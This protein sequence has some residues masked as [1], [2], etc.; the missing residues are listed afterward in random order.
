MSQKINKVRN[1][2]LQGR[3][4]IPRGWTWKGTRGTSWEHAGDGDHEAIQISSRTQKG[5]ATWSQV[6]SCKSETNY[7][8]EATISCGLRSDKD[9]GSAGLVLSVHPVHEDSEQ[10]RSR[11]TPGILRSSSPVAIRTIFLAG[12]GVRRLRISVGISHASGDAH[13]HEVRVIEMIDPD[14][15]SHPLAIPPPAHALPAPYKVRS[16][17][18]CSQTA[19]DRP[20][21]DLLARYFGRKK[22]ACLSPAD[23]RIGSSTADAI[24]FPDAAPPSGLRS[25]R[26]LFKLAGD[27]LVVIS[28]PAFAK[29]SNDA[30]RLR[31]ITQT[32]DPICAKVVWANHATRGFALNDMFPFAW[33]GKNPDSF[34][35][36]QFRRG[37]TLEPFCKKHGL[38]PLLESVCDQDATSDRPIC[39]Y[40]EI[41][42]GGLFVIDIEPVEAPLTT[43]GESSL[44]MYL[45]LSLL[46][47]TQHGLGQFTVPELETSAI[48]EMVRESSIRFAPFFVHDSGLPADEITEQLVTIGGG[49][50]GYGLSLN[51]KPVILV[52]SGLEHS[53]AVSVYGTFFWFKNLVRMVPHTC[54]YATALISRFQLAWSPLAA[55][56]EWELGWRRPAEASSPP[57]HSRLV[58]S[59]F[60]ALVDMVSS[61]ANR[62][63]VVVPRLTG[64]YARYKRWLPAL[65]DTFRA[66]SYF[67]PQSESPSDR[68]L[69]AWQRSRYDLVVEADPAGFQESSHRQAARAGA[70]L[71]RI[72]VPGHDA[73]FV[74]A[75]IQR[76]DLVATLLEQVVGLQFGLIASNRGVKT[77]RFDGFAPVAPGAAL[78]VLQNDTALQVRSSRAG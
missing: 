52:R 30:L 47:Q 73:D 5:C 45:L 75:S 26:S 25:L 22:V 76:T 9:D 2:S 13:V 50:E 51:P 16:V 69:F 24:L 23:F 49:D 64:T 28:L 18:V 43:L 4:G 35:Q 14:A 56:W 42:G 31:R 15:V 10:S 38:I 41:S 65:W 55:D 74:S 62:V 29:L 70:E 36:N 21:T 57:L 32:D 61:P 27:R 63:R 1:P 58:D 44:A 54:P 78:I 6:V 20:L 71:I 46:G 19:A 59:P 39:F 34:V 40:K 66:G 12:E 67:C 53:D 8:I 3:K 68:D 37:K 60:A 17:C 48:R 72:E 33:G 11:S 77:V 7:R